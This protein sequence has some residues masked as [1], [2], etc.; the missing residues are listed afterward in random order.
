MRR[1]LVLFLLAF[2]LSAQQ[3]L[4]LTVD[5]IMRGNGLAGWPPRAVR[6]SPDGKAVYFEWKQYTDPVEKDY[7]TYVA[8]RDGKGLRKLSDDEAKDAP[9]ARASWSRDRK[10]AVFTDDGDVFLWDGKRRALTKTNDVES[11]ARFT[12]DEKRV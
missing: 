11:H 4:E 12:H 10:R 3:R 7:D 2:S 6:W 5:A 8:G 9:P 1:L